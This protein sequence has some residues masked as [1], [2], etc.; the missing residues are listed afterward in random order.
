MTIITMAVAGVVFGFVLDYLVARLAREPYE[1]SEAPDG[2]GSSLESEAARLTLASIDTP[3]VH[4]MPS[5][6]TTHSRYRTSVV[7]AL[8][9]AVFGVIGAQYAQSDWQLAIASLYASALIICAATDFL[10][11]RVPNSV[12]YPAIVGAFAVALRSAAGDDS[13]DLARVLVERG[14]ARVA[15]AG[16]LADLEFGA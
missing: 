7:V 10:S 2:K 8:T 12:T 1:R 16:G 4:E 15:L 11:Y 3:T 9:A 6:L 5:L 14:A 13:D